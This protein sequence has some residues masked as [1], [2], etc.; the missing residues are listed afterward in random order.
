MANVQLTWDKVRFSATAVS[1]WI[2]FKRAVNL[3]D[4]KKLLS[5]RAVYVI[6]ITRPYSFA[7]EKGHSPV[8]YIG[9]GKAQQRITSH[10]GSWIKEL[11]KRIPDLHIEIWFCEPK[12]TWHGTIC[13]HVE[14]DLIKKFIAKYG[15]RPLRNRVTP[16]SN[17]LHQYRPDDMAILHPGKGKGYHWA[18]KPLPSSSFY[19]AR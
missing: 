5:S 1:G 11:G 14:S 3:E 18:I 10:L 7:Y 4:H 15:D 17:R 9:K 13:E 16:R 6:R 19:K 8:A 12:A 2:A